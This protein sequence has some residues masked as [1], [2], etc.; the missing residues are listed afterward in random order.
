MAKTL[1]EVMVQI[2]VTKDEEGDVQVSETAHLTVST[3]EYPEF[4]SRKGISIELTP[5]Q[6]TAIINHVKTVVLPQ[7]ELAK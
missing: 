1:K 5:T 4:E 6:K 2:I 7:A 3:D